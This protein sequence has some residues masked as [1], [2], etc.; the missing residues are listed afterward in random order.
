VLRYL[1]VRGPRALRGLIVR[2]PL[3]RDPKSVLPTEIKGVWVWPRLGLGGLSR[4]RGHWLDQREAPCRSRLCENA[5]T[6]MP[7]PHRCRRCG[8]FAMFEAILRAS[9]LLSNFA[10]ERRPGSSSK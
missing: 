1:L 3:K 10:A 2:V 8:N 7:V 4:D 6:A 5:A 9:S